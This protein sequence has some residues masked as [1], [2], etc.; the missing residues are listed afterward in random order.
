[1]TVPLLVLALFA[2]VLGFIGLPHLELVRAS[3][4]GGRGW[5]RAVA[6]ARPERHAGVQPT[7]RQ[8]HDETIDSVT[9]GLMAGRARDRLA[10]HRHRVACS[11]A[12][13]RRRRC[14][15]WSRARSTPLYNARKH[16]LWVDE[17]YDSIFV[18]PFRAARARPVRD[19]RSVRHRHR[20]GQRRGVRRRPVR[21][22]VALVPERPGPA[23]RR[24]ARHRRGRGVLRHRLPSPRRRST[25]TASIGDA[26]RAARRRR[27]RARR[28][29][30]EAALG[31][32]RGGNCDGDADQPGEPATRVEMRAA[33]SARTSRCASRIRS[34]AR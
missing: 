28:Q 2:T 4:A 17:L 5:P 19:R 14:R 26:D 8:I 1:M 6:L 25:T 23:L 10:R 15:S 21:P 13:V 29:G 30:D 32:R 18:K 22:A 20:R 34:R 27:C 7:A 31:P 9:L 33:T 24:R 3:R 12:T 11:T 16:K